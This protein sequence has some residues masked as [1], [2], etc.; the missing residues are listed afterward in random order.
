MTAR[1][2]S[3]SSR[4]SANGNGAQTPVLL[5]DRAYAELRRRILSG[6]YP[7]ETFLAERQLADQLG[8]SKTPV[9]AALERLVHEGFISV[10]PQQGIVVRSLSIAEIADQYE[11]RA[12]LESYTVRTLAGKLS[13]DQISQLRANLA[14]QK[15]LTKR[16]DVDAA[17]KLDAAFH[18]LF[19][20]FLSNK[21]ILR[22][23][24]QLRD[25]MGMVIGTVFQTH[26]GRI[27]SSYTEH[28]AIAE[29]V[30]GG[31]GARA[32]RLLEEHLEYGK[33]LILM[34]RPK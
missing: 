1:Q 23:I 3:K 14:A 24:C 7:P 32:A 2:Q 29:A 10:S 25:K 16:I 11:I 19:P 9:K 30:I 34:R 15:K 20:T 33:S 6:E 18:T 13:A 5:K 12:A 27:E 8:M 22:V 4:A 17:V 21:E 26:P 28:V 31:D